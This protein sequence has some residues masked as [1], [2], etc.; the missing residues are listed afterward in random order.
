MSTEICIRSLTFPRIQLP[1]TDWM[2]PGSL[3]MN[4]NLSKSVADIFDDVYTWNDTLKKPSGKASYVFWL[5]S[6]IPVI[7]SIFSNNP[8][9]RAAERG[10]TL[11]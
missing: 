8:N 6:C 9:A 11:S 10:Y 2:K 1:S 3:V 4:H 5:L 7:I